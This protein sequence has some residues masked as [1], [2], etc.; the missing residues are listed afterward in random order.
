MWK[1]VFNIGELKTGELKDYTVDGI[2]LLIANS[3]GKIYITALYCTHE[4]TALSEG[5]I[6]KCN[7]ICPNHYAKFNLKDGSVVSGPEDDD[8]PIKAL[9][10]YPS[11]V[12]NGMIMVD[13]P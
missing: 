5:F 10:T 12:E 2:P 13:L 3:D 1:D 11:K 8:T 4:A 6:E 9:K 7:V